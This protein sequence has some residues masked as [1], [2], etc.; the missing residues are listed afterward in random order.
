[1]PGPTSAQPTL[2]PPVDGSP[3]AS[4]A[5]RN[6]ALSSSLL[7]IARSRVQHIKD[8]ELIAAPA[9]DVVGLPHAL[10]EEAGDLLKDPVT[11]L[12]AQRIVDGFEIVHVE[13]QERDWDTVP[14]MTI[15]FVTNDV[16]EEAS[17]V[18]ACQ[19]VGAGNLV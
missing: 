10:L 17:V 5:A 14:T 11:R 8:H 12:V 15:E 3:D 7:C 13:E 19:R 18:A 16:L 9:E 4:S 1:M 6:A 2:S